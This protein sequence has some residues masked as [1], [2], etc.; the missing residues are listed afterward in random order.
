MCKAV[1]FKALHKCGVIRSSN[2]SNIAKVRT[3]QK[4][5]TIW[6]KIHVEV[7]QCTA[8]SNCLLA[9][10]VWSFAVV[11]VAVVTVAVVTVAVEAAQ[12]AG[13]QVLIQ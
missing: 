9:L 11:T 6:P 2:S 10:W 13:R 5:N 8:I 1:H 4:K 3:L 12:S 7:A